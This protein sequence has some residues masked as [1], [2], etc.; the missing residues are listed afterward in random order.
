MYIY[1]QIKWQHHSQE[2][3]QSLRNLFT[4]IYVPYWISSW[5]AVNPSKKWTSLY[6]FR[7]FFAV[8][9]S[10]EAWE[11]WRIKFKTEHNSY[12]NIPPPPQKTQ[13]VAVLKA[14]KPIQP[15]SLWLGISGVDSPVPQ[16]GLTM[17]DSLIHHVF[18]HKADSLAITLQPSPQ[19]GLSNSPYLKPVGTW[20]L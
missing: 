11:V 7:R 5:S 17:T 3:I 8:K 12:I 4:N 6:S 13:K 14:T 19:T 9:M 1:K 10:C 15:D 2:Q 16:K 20:Y 18:T